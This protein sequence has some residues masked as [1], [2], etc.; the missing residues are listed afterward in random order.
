M[1]I[2]K[3]RLLFMVLGLPVFLHGCYTATLL[4]FD[5][6]EPAEVTLPSGIKTLTVIARCDLDSTYRQTA[7]ISGK[8]AGFKRDSL[9]SKQMVVGCSDAMV[10]SPRY[11]LNN[12]VLKRTLAG[13]YHDPD[14]K[15]PWDAIRTIAGN[16]PQ[17]AILSLEYASVDDT[18]RF[19]EDDWL[20]YYQYSV[21]VK[22]VWRLYRLDD[23]QSRDFRFVDT[24]SFEIPSPNEFLSSP[25]NA[26]EC[27]REAMYESGT[28]TAR[29]LAPWWTE[30]RRNFFMV[31]PMDFLTGATYLR[32]GQWRESAEIW[33][34]FIS[35]KNKV[36][37]GKACFNMAV[38]SEM[39]GK[40]DA[41]LEWLK[42]AESLGVDGY[43]IKE[44]RPKLMKRKAATDKLDSQ[45]K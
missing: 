45:M 26:L 3:W 17:D 20:G 13:N 7:V 24:V 8:L 31:G 41:A 27:I 6:L 2:M 11:T 1:V 36:K 12:P 19:H 33:Q 16:P 35:S 37:A 42:K 25:E 34:R 40:P 15:L 9:M 14:V 38:T 30:Y 44:Y 43:F 22:S 39:A 18:I 29:R 28:R 5:A 32:E 21:L 23:F 10:E 4:E